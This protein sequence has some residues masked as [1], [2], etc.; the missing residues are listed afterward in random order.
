MRINKIIT[1]GKIIYLIKDQILSTNSLRICLEISMEN[2][3]VYMLW[4]N[5]FILGLIFI[6]FCFK[7]IIIYY[8]TQK[9]KKIKIKPRIK[10]NHNIYRAGGL[11]GEVLSPSSHT[12]IQAHTH[13]LILL[14]N[15]PVPSLDFSGSWLIF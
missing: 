1:R 11:K 2:L 9:Q 12:P 4:F 14:L 5:Y 8:H 13:S 7:L 15:D 6:F 10:L 3:Y